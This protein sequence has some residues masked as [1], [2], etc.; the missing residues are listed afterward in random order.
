VALL[1]MVPGIDETLRVYG[2]AS[3]VVPDERE[4]AVLGMDGKGR[5]VLRVEVA[6]AFFHCAKALMRS[7]L[8]DPQT[9]IDRGDFPTMG[10]LMSDHAGLPGS[11]ESQEEMLIRYQPTL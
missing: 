3:I 9:R 4:R 8:W 11:V 10:Q 1:F 5:S 2:Q 6:R 7:A